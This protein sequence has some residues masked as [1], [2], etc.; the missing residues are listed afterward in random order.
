MQASN[1]HKPHTHLRPNTSHTSIKPAQTSPTLASESFSYKHQ[2]CTNLTPSCVWILLIISSNLPKTPSLLRLNPS[3]ASIKP[4]KNSLTLAFG[5]FSCLHQTCTNLTHSCV[6]ILLMQVFNL[7]KPQP[8]LHLN[9]SHAFIKPAQTSPFPAS[10]NLCLSCGIKPAQTSPTPVSESFPYKYQTCTNLT[11]SCLWNLLRQASN[12]QKPHF[13]LRLNPYHTSSRPAKN[14]LT[15]AF[16]S[17]SC[18]HQTCTN[19]TH[20]CVWIPLKR[21][22]NLHKP[23]PLLRLNLSH[24]CKIPVQTSPTLAFESF[25]YKHQTCKKLTHSC[26]WILLML[27]SNLHKP[28]SLLRLNPSHAFIKPAQTSPFPA[29]QYLSSEHQTCTNLTHSCVWILPIQ[30]SNLHKPHPLL[31]LN[32]S[33]T[34]IKPAQTSLPLASESF[35]YKQQTCKKLTHSCVWILLMLASNLHKPH[36]LLRLNPSEA[37]IKPA[38]TSPTLAFESFACKHQ[39]CKKLTHSCV[40]ILLM[41]ASNLHKPHPLLRLNPSHAFIKPAQTSPFPASQ[42][43]SCEHQTCTNLTHSCLCIL[44]RQV[45]NLHKPH[46]LL[47]LNPYHTSSKPAKN[48]LTLAFESFSC[49]HQT[50]KKLTHSCVWILPIQVSN[51]H[52]PHPLLSLYPS[53]TSIKP[54]QTSLPLASESLSYKQQTCK[55]LTHSCVW[56]LLMFAS[57]L[58]KPHPLLR[59]NP[60]EASI[61]P[62]QTSPTLAF[63]SFSCLQNTCA[64][65][66][67]SCVWILLI[68]AS[69]LQ[70][71]HSLLRLNPS[72]ACIKPAQTSL[73][74]ASESFSDKHQTCTNMN[75]SC[76]WILIR[77]A[78]NLQKTHSLLRLNPSHACIKPA[79]TSPTPASESLWSEHQTC[80]NL[81]HSCVWILLMQ[82]SNLQ[83]THS[84]LRLN[85]SHACIKPAQASPTP[86]SESFS[87][88]HQTCANLT[89]S[90]VSI[91]IMRASNL[92]KPHPLL[93]LNPSHTSIKPAQTSPTPVSE[94]FS[95]KHQTCT[96]L[97]SSCVWILIIQAA[98]LQKTHSLFRLN[99]SHVCIKPAQTSPTPA[100]ESFSSERQICTNLTHSCVW[101]LLMQ[102]FNLHKPQPLLH[103][104]SSH[105]SIK[106]AQTSPT[107][108]SESFS[109]FHQTSANL[110]H[111]CIWIPLKRASNLHKPHPLLR[112]NLSHACKIPVQTSPTLA[113]ES[114]SYKH[115]T[116]KKLTHSCV[117]ILL[118]LA[119]NLHKP[120]SL[121]RLNPSQASVKSAQTSPTPA[122]ESF[123]CKHLTCTNLNHSCIWFLLI[124]ASNLHKLHPLLRLN[125]SHAF[126]KPP[127]TSPTHA[128]QSLSCVHQTCRN[129]THTCVWILL[130]Q[131]SNL[132]KPHTL[133][134]LNPSHTS[135]KPAQTSPSPA[136]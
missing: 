114:F 34:S 4:A 16:E 48:S 102:A 37:S 77:Q 20:S 98:N 21:A 105:T 107:L 79:Q 19:L 92:H 96:N 29:S 134:R 35:S 25:S 75:S 121:L 100:S 56:I 57:N 45:S 128:S 135:I 30:V 117:W 8:L 120:H 33:Q 89:L 76:V 47:R 32:P 61:K 28:H 39:T 130:T 59:L 17:F 43:L 11:H 122:S 70:K 88:F 26:V 55:K 27:A 52:E 129:L 60:S 2:T 67:H 87:W 136:S 109:C 84:L 1:L 54:A 71:T 12:L 7:P 41:L 15:L 14:S 104:I 38:Q 123:S 74:P 83:K 64:N 6:W 40:W 91:L 124:Q 94:S 49:L 44:L 63:E 42:Y 9:P 82:A 101:I 108:A 90:C 24:A 110:T 99:P 80:T 125:P 72:H 58:H 97:T 86:A 126:I 10:Q 115:Q 13:L 111:S 93:R 127:Q 69:N 62:A 46:F 73:T 66:T 23:H 85:P 68:Q 119:S 78:A 95:D 132:H 51:L 103:L 31:S 36:P 106:P 131:A 116:C 5:S 3:H 22:S 112:M 81:T 133:L 53:Q 113:F 118:M 18:L 65:L 50:C